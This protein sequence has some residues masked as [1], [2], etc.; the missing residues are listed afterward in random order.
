MS[1]LKARVSLALSLLLACAAATAQTYPDR[2][3][4]LVVPFA[5][6]TATDVIARA[7]AAAMNKSVGTIIVD[8]KA[9]ALG[10]IGT[11]D[12]ARAKPDGYTVLLGGSTSM[13][14]GPQMLRQKP[15]YDAENDFI[16]IGRLAGVVF[17]LVARAEL[18]ANNLDEFL[19][20]ARKRQLSWGYANS[21]NLAAGQVFVNN[22]KID[23]L[24]VPYK[25]VPQLIQDMLGGT[26][27]F[28]VVDT[29]NAMPQVRAG[30]LRA[31]AVSTPAE[32]P[33]MPGVPPLNR[34]SKGFQ[35]LVWTGVFVPKGTPEPIV[36][37]LS[38]ALKKATE[39]PQLRAT[40]TNAGNIVMYGD[41]AE[42]RAYL[43]E[44]IARWADLVKA[45]NIQPE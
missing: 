29:A 30:K 27:D 16:P 45:A 5:A 15:T 12:A 23:A 39:D 2:P 13:S 34:V 20:V 1:A 44:D 36:A 11:A 7:L 18:G 25:G 22:A 6:G 4:R 24:K 32:N 43:T 3:I 26:I 14:A 28:A 31:L 33:G 10:S 9:G 35:L 19:E 37:V 17:V 21:A 8:N 41:R 40:L 38:D 42:M